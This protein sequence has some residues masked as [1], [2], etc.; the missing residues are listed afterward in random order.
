MS[1]NLLNLNS[2]LQVIIDT[3]FKEWWVVLLVALSGVFARLILFDE[4]LTLLEC[5]RRVFSAIILSIIAWFILET[6][7]WSDAT[8]ILIY[9]VIGLDAPQ[10]ISG[11][12]KTISIIAYSPWKIFNSKI[13]IKFNDLD[14]STSNKTNIQKK[15]TKST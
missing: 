6:I 1:T 5:I 11:I 12:V 7:E 14:T 4:T 15:K 10:I 3:F 8:K 13:D 2:P 9:A